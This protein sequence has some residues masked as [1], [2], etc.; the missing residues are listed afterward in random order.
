MGQSA[1]GQTWLNIIQRLT[2]YIYAY[3]Y[4]ASNKHSQ[5]MSSPYIHTVPYLISSVTLIP[6]KHPIFFFLSI[7]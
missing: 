4:I 3:V 5:K 2:V 7:V 6:E 1:E